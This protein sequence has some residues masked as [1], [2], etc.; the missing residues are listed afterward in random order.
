MKHLLLTTIAQT[1]TTPVIES[2]H[3]HGTL[4]VAT[5]SLGFSSPTS[6]ARWRGTGRG[7]WVGH[8]ADKAKREE[9]ERLMRQK[10]NKTPPTAADEVPTMKK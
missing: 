5:D 3:H 2:V 9:Y 8:L 7:C 10:K 4:G 6:S 1:F